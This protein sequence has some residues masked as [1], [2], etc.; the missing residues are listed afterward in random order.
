[1]KFSK[2]VTWMQLERRVR[3]LR[4]TRGASAA[5]Q[6]QRARTIVDPVS[7]GDDFVDPLGLGY[8]TECFGFVPVLR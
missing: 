2:L 7:R 4:E 3:E 5:V 6:L 1:M 8:V